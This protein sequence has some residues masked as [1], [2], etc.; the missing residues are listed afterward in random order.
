LAASFYLVYVLEIV[1]FRRLFTRRRPDATDAEVAEHLET[2]EFQA[3]E[4]PGPD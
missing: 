4:K 2:G 1:K 3:L